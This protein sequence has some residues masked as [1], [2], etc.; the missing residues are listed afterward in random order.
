MSDS[1]ILKIKESVALTK[2]LPLIVVPVYNHASTLLAVLHDLSLLEYPVLIVNDGST[3]KVEIPLAQFPQ[4]DV[5]HHPHNRGKGAAIATAMGFAADHGYQAILTFDADGQHL[6][7]D[8]SRLVAVH[9]GAPEALIIGARD[10]NNPASGDVPTSSKFGRS[11]S[12]FWIWTE[13]GRWLSDTQTGLRIYPV[14]TAWLKTVKGYRYSFEIE[15]ITRLLWQGREAICVPVSTYYP[16]RS[17]RISHF[18][19]VTDNF[20]NTLVHFRLLFLQVFKLLG[21]YRPKKYS[22]ARRPELKGIGMTASIIKHFGS[23]TAYMLMVL[24]VL[25]SL[26]S[27]GYERRGALEFYKRCRPAWR[28]WRRVLGV[29]HNYAQFGASIIDR[30]NPEGHSLVVPRFTSGREATLAKALPKGAI[31][32]GAHYGDWALIASRVKPFLAGT[33]GLVADPSVTPQF[34]AELESRFQGK[35]RVI[36]SRQDV[37]G[38]ALS[39]KEVLDDNGNVAFLADR[40][41]RSGQDETL[42]CEF[43]GEVCLWPKAPFALAARLQVPVV[44]LSSTKGGLKPA[45]TYSIEFQVLCQGDKRIR[46]SE[47][48]KLYV[49][50]LELRVAAAPQHWFNFFPFW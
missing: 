8:I 15:A 11:F 28:P 49:K 30:T 37:L 14:D 36:N 35:L 10:F 4:Y 48:L 13:T 32:L 27:R 29:L 44:F 20:W 31:L 39:V 22:N 45:D 16:L 50:A 5:V 2:K 38:F 19:A 17:E 18:H 25:Y 24:P 26:L 7:R 42:S 3:D 23:P 21:I 12:N 6:A 33:L 41:D 9:R 1:P 46:E 43:F 34:F 40:S 47:V